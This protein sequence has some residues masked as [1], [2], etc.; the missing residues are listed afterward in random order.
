IVASG[1]PT[2][3]KGRAKV[4]I[5]PGLGAGKMVEEAKFVLDL[6]NQIVLN[7]STLYAVSSIIT[8]YGEVHDMSLPKNGNL[9]D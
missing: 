3:P 7:K 9:L 8:T 2:S 6:V 5:R 4:F 1:R